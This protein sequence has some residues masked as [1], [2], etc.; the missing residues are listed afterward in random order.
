[1]DLTKGMKGNDN[2]DNDDNGDYYG[3]RNYPN[4]K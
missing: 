4:S 3:K 1:M 2:N